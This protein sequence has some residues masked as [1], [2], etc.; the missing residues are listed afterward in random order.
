LAREISVGC[1][2]LSAGSNV[3]S[4]I[5]SW[6]I[7]KDSAKNIIKKKICLYRRER[8]PYFLKLVL[9]MEY[10]FGKQIPG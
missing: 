8:E 6:Q 1:L 9:G 5:W 10:P 2:R 7:T 3:S 4:N